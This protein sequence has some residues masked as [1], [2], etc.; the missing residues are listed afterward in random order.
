M[1]FYGFE[2]CTGRWITICLRIILDFNLNINFPR[3]S[4][5]FVILKLNFIL[6]FYK[7]FE[8]NFNIKRDHIVR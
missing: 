2:F 4:H 7:E 6:I 1:N 3:L 8:M 5:L